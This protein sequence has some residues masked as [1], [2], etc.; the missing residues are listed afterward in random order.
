MDTSET[1]IVSHL[2]EQYV[3]VMTGETGDAVDISSEIHHSLTTDR[4]SNL[5][6]TEA[7][8]ISVTPEMTLADAVGLMQAA[9]IGALLVVDEHDHPVGIF[10]ERDVLHKVAVQIE[11]LSAH[12]VAE[13]M[14]RN[15]DTLPADAPIAHALHL[16][17]IHHYRHVPI[18]DE[19]GAALNIIS[20][21]DVVHYIETYF[22]KG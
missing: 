17:A 1:A 8:L 7:A 20:F 12:T 2:D 16:M 5:F 9:N 4:I 18:V 11:D 22:D 15:P 10:T 19:Q 3:D 13:F 21:R 6:K 14:T